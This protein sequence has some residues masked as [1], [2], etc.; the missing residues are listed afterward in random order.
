MSKDDIIDFSLE[1]NEVLSID[2]LEYLAIKLGHRFKDVKS[3]ENKKTNLL[4][5]VK[6]SSGILLKSYLYL[7]KNVTDQNLTPPSVW[8]LDN[9]HVIED[10]LRSIKR[11]LPKDFY[12]E[13]PKV[14][15]GEFLGQPRVFALAYIMTVKTDSRL[16]LNSLIRFI[17]AFQSV[18]P[19]TIGELWAVA[20]TF[21][22]SLIKQLH[23]LVDLI[24][25]NHQKRKE[26]DELADKLLE[27]S[28][29]R[30]TTSTDIIKYLEQ[31]LGPIDKINRP[32]IV[33]LI[34]RLRDQNT[35]VSK[36][37]EWLEKKLSQ[38]DVTATI[39]VQHEHYQLASDQVT[40]GNIISS[41]RLI[42]SID[43]HDFFEK[44]SLVD[45]ILAQD[46]IGAYS[47]MDQATRDSYRNVIEKI[48]RRTKV[49]ELDVARKAIDLS[50]CVVSNEDKDLRKKHVGYFLLDHGFHELQ[51]T[52]NYRMNTLEYIKRF[53]E[54]YPSFIYFGSLFVLM[55]LF[56]TVILN[57]FLKTI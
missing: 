24:I 46:P 18:T 15:E 57:I 19:L 27:L 49:N 32:L 51:R 13:L 38:L 14:Q 36:A 16:D 26:G 48:S 45:P 1:E 20:I 55:I 12:N 33:Q 23:P 21:R 11:D 47:Q 30:D 29:K 17:N 28:S 31:N 41:M 39:V 44:V 37:F 5:E 3:F 42:S 35:L 56:L 10:Q 9:F 22:I 43:W 40:I 4:G 34:A 7:I 52:L 8:F 2:R 25:L 50:R 53:I 6:N 54:T